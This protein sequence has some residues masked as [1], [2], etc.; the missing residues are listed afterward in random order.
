MA[1]K[2]NRILSATEKSEQPANERAQEGLIADQILS[3]KQRETAEAERSAEFR[4]LVPSAA[5]GGS[6]SRQGVSAKTIEGIKNSPEGAVAPEVLATTNV[7]DAEMKLRLQNYL[8]NPL[9]DPD[10]AVK[11]L[12]GEKPNN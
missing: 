2:P 12:M 4:V 7:T 5:D 3:K 9:S 11:F 1:T 8:D 10:A 6:V